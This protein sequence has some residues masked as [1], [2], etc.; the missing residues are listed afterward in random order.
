LR[1]IAEEVLAAA[2]GEAIDAGC[3]LILGD[4]DALVLGDAALLQ[5]MLRNLV[6]NALLHAGASQIEI[7]IDIRGGE[8]ILTV[9][10]DG[11]GIPLAERERVLQ[12]FRRGTSADSSD[13]A[14]K[15]SL[16]SGLGLSIVSRIVEVHGG[17]MQLDDGNDGRGLTVRI[18][19]PGV[20]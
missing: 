7:G 20:N 15:R 18:H 4:G 10:D 11:R 8:A 6:D 17:R 12:R 19:L 9:A 5:S 14:A 2:A 16:G 1:P 13:A 3:E